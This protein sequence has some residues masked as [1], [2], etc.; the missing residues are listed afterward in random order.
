MSCSQALQRA[1]RFQRCSHALQV[2]QPSLPRRGTLRTQDGTA[3]VSPASPRRASHQR[4]RSSRPHACRL[5]Y[6]E[7]SPETL[8]QRNL[9]IQR[10]L[11][12][13]GLWDCPPPPQSSLQ[14]PHPPPQ[15]P[16]FLV[17]QAQQCFVFRLQPPTARAHST[18]VVFWAQLQ[19]S[20]HLLLQTPP[21]PAHPPLPQPQHPAQ[22]RSPAS[23]QLPPRPQPRRLS[24]VLPQAP[25]RLT[26]RFLP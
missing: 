12:L 21:Y 9:H 13:L 17:P 15:S 3:L 26:F 18:A 5:A 10:P 1:L 22:S 16:H 24:H 20:P 25:L 4:Q 23:S 2:L 19:S 11:A 14:Q 7:Y 8:A 6:S